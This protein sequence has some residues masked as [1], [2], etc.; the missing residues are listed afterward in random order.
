[1]RRLRLGVLVSGRGSNL[2]ALIEACRAPE[3]PAAVVVV[4]A[5][6]VAPALEHAARAGIP[7]AVFDRADYPDRESRDLAMAQRLMGYRAELVVCAGYDAILKPAFT[8][9]FQGRILNIHPSLLPNFGGSMDAVAHALQ[10]GVRETGCTV[11]L[12]TDDV[13]SGPI[14]GQRR[15]EV[16]SDDT[17]ERLHARIQNE[18]HQ[19]LPDVIRQIALRT[20]TRQPV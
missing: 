6:K 10:A 11:H 5:N 14:L 16:R 1:M 3:F 9:E 2:N 17:V 20:P 19:L 4:C 12:L 18:E 13:D 15:V 7:Y 8:R